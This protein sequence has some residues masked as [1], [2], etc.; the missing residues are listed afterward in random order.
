MA[1][2]VCK[3][4]IL[5]YE[6]HTVVENLNF[7]VNSG[8]YLCIVGENGSGKSTLIKTLLNLRKPF[9]G[10]IRYGDGLQHNDIGYLPQQSL[11]QRDFPATVEEI[12]R[13]A[14]LNRSGWRPFYTQEEKKQAQNNMLKTGVLHLAK[15]CYRELSGGQQQRVLLAR[16]LGAATRLLLLDE[17]AAG[18]DPQAGEEMYTL[19]KDLNQRDGMT[20]I[21]VTHD[22]SAAIQ[23]ASHV[24]HVSHKPLFFGTAAGYQQSDIGKIY[25]CRAKGDE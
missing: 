24:L 22:V 1:L 3:D 21:M 5:A 14:C 4:V 11:V 15:R 7:C 19:I 23:Y 17:P 18:L 20:V 16:A 2:L 8:D 6:G 25:M 12:V 13:S 9:A 10:E